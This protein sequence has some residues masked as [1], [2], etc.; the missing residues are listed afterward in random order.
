MLSLF[1]HVAICCFC[2]RSRA[3]DEEISEKNNDEVGAKVTLEEARPAATGAT[4][5]VPTSSTLTDDEIEDTAGATD[6]APTS[7]T[8]TDV[9]IKDTAEKDLQE[10]STPPIMK[11]LS[12]EEI[13]HRARKIISRLFDHLSEQNEN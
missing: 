9:E 6:D 3:D 1:F 10:S 11:T 2:C 7:S 5:D 8:L 4:E 12:K 13:E